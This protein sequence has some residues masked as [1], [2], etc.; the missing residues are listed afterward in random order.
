VKAI[1]LSAGQGRRLMPLTEVTPK[2][3]LRPW[4]DVTI[5]EWQISQLAVSGIDEVVVVTG[6]G[7]EA[8]EEVIKGI[9]GIRVRTLFNPFYRLADNLGTC[10]V[11]RHEMEGPFVLINGDTLFEAA[12]LQHLLKDAGHYPITLATD[13][14]ISYDDD[15]MKIWSER[16]RLC[17]VGKTLDR[18]HVNGESIGMMVFH[19]TG[20]EIFVDKIESLMR[21][22][23]GLNRWYLSAIDELAQTRVVGISSIH[24]LSWCEVDDPVDFAHAEQVVKN[25]PIRP[26]KVQDDAQVSDMAPPSLHAYIEK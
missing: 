24:G 13:Q 23:D 17:R 2:C 9:T 14:K 25:W 4:G 3:C 11:A 16:D 21:K 1:I 6:F 7:D 15:D 22:G 19:Q 18:S 12:V 10:W 26:A 20:A 5:L 8:V